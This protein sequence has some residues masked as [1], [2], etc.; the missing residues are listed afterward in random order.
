MKNWVDFDDLVSFMRLFDE[1]VGEEY[2]EVFL[3]EIE[4]LN[5]GMDLFDGG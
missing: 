5:L 2:F 1:S 3:V 4:F